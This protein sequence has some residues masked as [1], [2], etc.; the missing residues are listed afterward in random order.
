MLIDMEKLVSLLEISFLTRGD[1]P[2]WDISKTKSDGFWF[3]MG[4]FIACEIVIY[5]RPAQSPKARKAR[6]A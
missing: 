3:N 4:H 2:F 5:R 6:K 1:I